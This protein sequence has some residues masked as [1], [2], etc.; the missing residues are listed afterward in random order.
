M[1][2]GCSSGISYINIFVTIVNLLF[3]FKARYDSNKRQRTCVLDPLK[4][5]FTYTAIPVGLFNTLP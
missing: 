4:R 5:A 3:T 2:A 1:S